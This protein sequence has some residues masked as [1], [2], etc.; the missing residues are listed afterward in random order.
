MA[1]GKKSIKKEVEETVDSENIIE[2][3][4]EQPTI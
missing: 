1:K 3:K 2:Q 4:S